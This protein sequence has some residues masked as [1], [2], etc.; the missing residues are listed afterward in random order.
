MV[1]DGDMIT[2]NAETREMNVEISDEEMAQRK[3]NFVPPPPKHTRGVLA[4]YVMT[5]KSASEGAVTGKK[6][7]E[8]HIG[9]VQTTNNKPV[10]R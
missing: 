8:K 10:I 4:R 6:L 1:K 3:A 2:I 7:T 9:S 5:V